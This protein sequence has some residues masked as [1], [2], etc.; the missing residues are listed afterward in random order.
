MFRTSLL[1]IALVQVAPCAVINFE[2]LPSS[3][4]KPGPPDNPASILTTQLSSLGVVFGRPGL[5]AGVS[6]VHNGTAYSSPN[7]VVGLDAAGNEPGWATGDIYLHFVQPGTLI[8][9]V[10]N[11]VS[12]AIGDGGGDVDNIIIRAY[13]LA[14]TQIDIQ[15]YSSTEYQIYSLAMAGIHR[16][17]VDF[18]PPDDTGLGGYHMD[19]LVFNDPAAAPE[20]ATMMLCGAALIALCIPRFRRNTN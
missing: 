8:P 2:G 5:S 6:V 3:G 9:S 14:D 18:L 12:F 15:F 13:D 10:T 16:L 11:L 19:D 7:S 17:E 4:S 1:L 20:P